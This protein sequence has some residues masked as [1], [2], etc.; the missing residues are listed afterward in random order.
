[1][2]MLYTQRF[3]FTT[4]S[5]LCSFIKVTLIFFFCFT[6][7]GVVLSKGREERKERITWMDSR[8]LLPCFKLVLDTFEL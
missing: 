3:F 7:V 5:V 1:M 8:E 4:A 6:R 2:F